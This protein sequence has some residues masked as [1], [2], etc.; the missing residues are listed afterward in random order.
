M[1]LTIGLPNDPELAAEVRQHL[2]AVT[3]G[4]A[5]TPT[6]GPVFK[7]EEP[8]GS[9]NRNRHERR[10]YAAR[11]RHI[12]H[13]MRR[14]DDARGALLKFFTEKGPTFDYAKL[15][16]RLAYRNYKLGRITARQARLFGAR[17]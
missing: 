8:R 13:A 15:M 3:V 14:M 2:D 6:V 7:N 11:Q 10:A 16:L 12:A 4:D 5:L 1:D 17:V 9:G